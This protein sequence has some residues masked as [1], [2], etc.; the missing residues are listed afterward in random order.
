MITC[1]LPATNCA[2]QADSDHALPFNSSTLNAKTSLPRQEA[3]P[4]YFFDQANGWV[5]RENKLYS[6]SD[7]GKTW[8]IINGDM[9]NCTKV[10]FANVRDGWV[11]RD[12]WT[13]G[14]LNFVL[15]TQDG[16]RSWHE[17][18]RIGTPIYSIDFL[19]EK[20]GF[21]SGRWTR[22]QRTTDG[23]ESWEELPALTPGLMSE[24]LRHLFFLNEKEGWGYGLSIWRTRD[25]GQTWTQMIAEDELPSD[26][27]Y[28]AAFLNNTTGR[29]VG[30]GRQVWFTTDGQTWRATKVSALKINPKEDTTES[31]S[32]FYSVDF[33]NPIN[34]WIASEDNSILHSTDGGMTW[35]IIAR[36]KN[37][38]SAIRFISEEEGWG[39]DVEGNLLHTIDGGKSWQVRRFE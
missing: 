7:S 10:I 8:K 26:E 25:G 31:P 13:Y 16:G 23:G 32:R 38:P 39:L 1:L 20:V 27:L 37:Q 2:S 18:M 12:E 15:R 35:Q 30:S 36:W 5:L 19:N 3:S 28:S 29:L 4:I 33:I 14:H 11:V 6:T 22:I 9:Q 24:G 17:V 34:G 21:V